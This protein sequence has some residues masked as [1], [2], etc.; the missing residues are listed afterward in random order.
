VASN[1]SPSVALLT[2]VASACTCAGVQRA[3]ERYLRFFTLSIS[4]S[5]ASLSVIAG[6]LGVLAVADTE[7]SIQRYRVAAIAI[8]MR[9]DVM[10]VCACVRVRLCA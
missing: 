1:Q 9:D 5:V 7:R 3:D 4:A 8:M 2:P 6:L 10:V